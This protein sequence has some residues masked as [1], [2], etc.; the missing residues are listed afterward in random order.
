MSLTVKIGKKSQIVIPKKLREAIGIS[1]GDEIIIDLEDD[2]IV[3]KPKPDS[4]TKKLKG[5][6][7]QLW[8]GVDAKR[9]VK[10]ERKAWD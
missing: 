5:L 3:I 6:H 1:E 4:Y 8:K 10:G 2:R 9:Y 7:R